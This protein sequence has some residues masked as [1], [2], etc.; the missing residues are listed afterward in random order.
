MKKMTHISPLRAIMIS[1]SLVN[2]MTEMYEF[3]Y[4]H[5]MN[6]SKL[7]EELSKIAANID[8]KCFRCKAVKS[9][10]ISERLTFESMYQFAFADASTDKESQIEVDVALYI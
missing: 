8:I 7:L 4:D 10:R 6:E 2:E 5:K 3:E 9:Y 1:E